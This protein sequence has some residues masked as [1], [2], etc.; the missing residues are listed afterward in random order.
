MLRVVL[1]VFFSLALVEHQ[2]VVNLPL[3]LEH[4]KLKMYSSRG[5]PHRQSSHQPIN[6]DHSNH[7]LRITHLMWH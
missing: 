3:P 2:G 5:K 7:L 1:K 4:S 6:P